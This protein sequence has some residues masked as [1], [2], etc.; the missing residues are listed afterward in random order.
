M[1]CQEDGSSGA[2]PSRSL[3]APRRCRSR[4]VIGSARRE[5][6]RRCASLAASFRSRCASC[7]RG[8]STPSA[9]ARGGA[10]ER[11][12]RAARSLAQALGE[13]KGPFAK[14]GQ[15]ASLRYD[16]LG[17]DVRE[18][19][20]TLQDRVPPLALRGDRRARRGG[21]RRAARHSLSR[22]R[23]AAA[24][25]G[26]GRAGASRAARAGGE[27]VAVKV[28]YPWL[29]HSLPADLAL[30]RRLL[31]AFASGRDVAASRA[32]LRGVRR[33]HRGRARLRARGAR[34]ARDRGEPRRRRAGRR[35]PDPRGAL[36]ATRP[37]DEL[38]AR[39]PDRGSRGASRARRAAARR[40]RDARA[41]LREAGLRG[42]PLP[43]RSASG[44]PLRH[45]RARDVRATARA[46]HRL[47]SL[48]APRSDPAPR[49]AA[50]HPR[51]AA[52]RRRGIPRRHG[53]HG[54]DRAGRARRR[55]HRGRRRC[56]IASPPRDRCWG[57]AAGRCWR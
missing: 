5:S 18:A 17:P 53:P 32:A 33:G 8:P 42:R 24:R 28:Q 2:A 55:A 11:Q 39:H 45:R 43:R 12:A 30:V 41:R 54:H 19:F 34:R 3:P 56:S 46:L 20:A 52:A 14:A 9:T 31:R 44:Q 4:C 37:R 51:A 22:L 47:R 57:S 49:A 23:G 6:P 10:G 36:H 21:A 27:P 26:L 35:A 29:A 16:V 13:L 7:W 38:P 15:F 40:A 1:R 25:R 50:G 48:E